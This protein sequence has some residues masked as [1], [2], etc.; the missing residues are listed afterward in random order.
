MSI[1]EFKYYELDKAIDERIAESNDI[2]NE[3]GTH[4]FDDEGR[5]QNS[6]DFP[7]DRYTLLGIVQYQ[8]EQITDLQKSVG[9]LKVSDGINSSAIE[10][11]LERVKDVEKYKTL[12]DVLTVRVAEIENERSDMDA[13][14]IERLFDRVTVLEN[15]MIDKDLR[16]SKLEKEVEKL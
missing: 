8:Q 13:K 15:E 2:R 3:W 7:L 16:I 11:L 12:I 5:L 6:E 4:I 10:M 14:M 1:I 9:R